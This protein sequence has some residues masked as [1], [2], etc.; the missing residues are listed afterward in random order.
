MD[1]NTYLAQLRENLTNAAELGGPQTASTAQALAKATEQANRLVL[2]HAL[3]D[4]A[5]EVNSTLTD[6][7]IHVT[8][9]DGDVHVNVR[10]VTVPSPADEHPTFE[11]ITG[12]ISRVTLRLVDQIKEKAEEAASQNGVSLN[13]WVSQAVKSALRDNWHGYAAGGHKS[14]GGEWTAGARHTS[15]AHEPTTPS[16]AAKS[17]TDVTTPASGGPANSKGSASDSTSEP[18]SPPTT[19]D[20]REPDSPPAAGTE[21]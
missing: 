18:T 7:Q 10:D 16:T 21:D 4:F 2:F 17:A 19:A 11:D 9:A 3:S 14:W 20:H 8:L 15:S 5:S 1:L 12:D 13:S 6:Q